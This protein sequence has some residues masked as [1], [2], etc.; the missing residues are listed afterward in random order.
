[1]S[2]SCEDRGG[3]SR[4]NERAKN[5]GGTENTSEEYEKRRLWEF[6]CEVSARLRRATSHLA[7]PS[8]NRVDDNPAM[9]TKSGQDG[10]Q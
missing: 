6:F 7:T 8:L 2:C 10:E 5:N 3:S 9:N 4:G 1:M